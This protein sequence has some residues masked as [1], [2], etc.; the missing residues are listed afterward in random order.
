MPKSTDIIRYGSAIAAAG[1]AVAVLVATVQPSDTGPF[2]I[3]KNK[4]INLVTNIT[5]CSKCPAVAEAVWSV[6]YSVAGAPVFPDTSP[7]NRNCRA[8]IP[9]L[10]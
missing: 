10:R 8:T 1:L 2:N 9:K 5:A 6:G 4:K 3:F 7:T